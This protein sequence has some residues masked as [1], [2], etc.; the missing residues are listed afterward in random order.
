M[1]RNLEN[2]I[3]VS[4]WNYELNKAKLTY[5]MDGRWDQRASGKEYNSSSDCVVSVGGYM[6]KVCR[7]VY[8]SK[9]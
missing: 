4:P 3:A 2:E 8:Y 9:R 7:L 1:D 6:K 5:M